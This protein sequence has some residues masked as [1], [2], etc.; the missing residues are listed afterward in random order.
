MRLN[1]LRRRDFLR[2]I[3]GAAVAWPQVVRA[4][5]PSGMRRIGALRAV[6]CASRGRE[7]SQAQPKDTLAGILLDWAPFQDADCVTAAD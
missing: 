2:S 3:S 5:Q 6:V 7:L 4:Q 1:Y